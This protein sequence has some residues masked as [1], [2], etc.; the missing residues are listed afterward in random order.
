MAKPDPLPDSVPPSARIETTAGRVV[1]AM[2]AMDPSANGAAG[3]APLWTTTA[4]A[5]PPDS[6]TPSTLRPMTYPARPAKVPTSG[7]HEAGDQHG[8][9][10]ARPAALVGGHRRG[11]GG[12]GTGGDGAA[13]G[14]GIG[15]GGG[16]GAPE[17]GGGSNGGCGS[18]MA[19]SGAQGTGARRPAPPY[20]S[21][22]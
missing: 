15:A 14:T 7:G 3:R 21:S 2:S 22:G 16:T 9:E 19:A 5:L 12:G 10:D 11:G 13:I 6:S 18:D 1:A 20:G 4:G 17:Y 8:A